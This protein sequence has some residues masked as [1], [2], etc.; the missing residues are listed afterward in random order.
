MQG[1]DSPDRTDTD[2]ADRPTPLAAASDGRGPDGRFQAGNRSGAGNPFA[3][4]VA[5][6]RST[7]LSSVTPQAMAEIT[8]RLVE[9]AK[10][11]NVAAIREVFDRTIG[12]PVETDLIERMEELETKLATLQDQQARR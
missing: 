1:T 3:K 12:K 9:L 2:T 6:L 10:E 4:Q 5:A 11:G 8:S 7:L